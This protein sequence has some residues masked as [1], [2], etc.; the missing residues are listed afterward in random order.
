ML[1][2]GRAVRQKRRGLLA[3]PKLT[4]DPQPDGPGEA[5]SRSD[6][7]QALQLVGRRSGDGGLIALVVLDLDNFDWLNEAFGSDVGDRA[8]ERTA[9]LLHHF[10]AAN[11]LVGRLDG[12]E[13]GIA[14]RVADEQ[15]ALRLAGDVLAL[16]SEP[17]VDCGRPLRL[18]ARA[19]V[20]TGPA[21]SLAAEALLRRAKWALASAKDDRPA[22]PVL[23]SREQW[24]AVDRRRALLR[25][26]QPA[27][28]AHQFRLAYQTIL[29]I[30]NKKVEM[31]E[32]LL[33]WRTPEG[34]D[35]PPAEFVPL[36]EE[37]GLIIP[38]GA[39][40]LGEALHTA[41]VLS[42]SRRPLTIAVN[43]SA[44]Q[45]C[46]PGLA[47]L[48]GRL[49][50]AHGVEPSL[51]AFEISERT[52][53][54]CQPVT[55]TIHALRDLGCKVGLDDFGTGQSCLSY[56]RS[57]PLD[58]IKIDRSFVCAL[59]TD[60][61]ALRL[62]ETIVSLAQDLG[63]GTVA[64]GIETPAQCEAARRAG[65]SHAQGFLFGKPSPFSALAGLLST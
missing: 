31:L 18:T 26:L 62:V 52:V 20:G 30:G 5:L 2:A 54:G 21:N 46:Q 16:V 7:L 28:D 24:P 55:S 17:F 15:S 1:Q 65:C 64:E 50:Q 4:D 43:I 36:A 19:G 44:R 51:L 56:L 25:S 60:P 49:L 32:A 3:F 57:L 27:F 6:F 9:G 23:C 58:F 13:F 40:V 35:I 53:A 45:F 39:W 14:A 59:G 47:G 48:V 61:R 63:M 12:D 29:N 41:S 34:L 22:G 38:L 33:R 8:L 42:R 10:L 11:T 37:T